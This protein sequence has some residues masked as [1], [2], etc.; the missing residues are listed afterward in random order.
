MRCSD[1]SSCVNVEVAVLGSP[2]LLKKK[3]EKK[4]KK[5]KKG[6]KKEEEEE[7]FNLYLYVKMVLVAGH[8]NVLLMMTDESHKTASIHT[9]TTTLGSII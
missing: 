3:E 9:E 6:K 2:S 7:A 1:L 8:F 5:K 4:K